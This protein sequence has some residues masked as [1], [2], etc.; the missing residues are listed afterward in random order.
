MEVEDVV[1]EEAVGDDKDKEAGHEEEPKVPNPDLGFC[2]GG[3]K[4]EGFFVHINSELIRS[5]LLGFPKP[6]KVFQ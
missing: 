3:Q 2:L 4:W 1:D 6:I 5:L